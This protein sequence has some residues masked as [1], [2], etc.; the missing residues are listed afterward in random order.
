[1]KSAKT[2]N[3]RRTLVTLLCWQKV[4]ALLGWH[5]SFLFLSVFVFFVSGAVIWSRSRCPTLHCCCMLS[6]VLCISRSRF[7]HQLGLCHGTWNTSRRNIKSMHRRW[8]A[9]VTRPSIPHQYALARHPNR[10]DS[11]FY[12]VPHPL[13]YV[14]YGCILQFSF[15]RCPSSSV[16]PAQF[17]YL[18]RVTTFWFR[19]RVESLL[20]SFVCFR[21][22]SSPRCL[23]S[24]ARSVSCVTLSFTY[25]FN[26]PVCHKLRKVACMTIDTGLPRLS[27][28]RIHAIRSYL[29]LQ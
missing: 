13:V 29:M 25:R 18:F 28:V 5:L 2:L 10:L 24:P 26:G 11:G 7:C 4:P 21:S 20:F 23:V 14:C 6:M 3:Y 12:S 16:S 17:G 1:M 15:L 9:A 22:F 8:R 19:Q 27:K